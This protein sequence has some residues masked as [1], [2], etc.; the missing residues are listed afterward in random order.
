L[1]FLYKV[2]KALA[3][4]SDEINLIIKDID[5]SQHIFHSEDGAERTGMRL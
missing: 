3:V 2:G 5:L 4:D 1:R